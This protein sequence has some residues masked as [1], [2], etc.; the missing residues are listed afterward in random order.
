MSDPTPDADDVVIRGVEVDDETRCAHYDGDSD[1]VAIA[2]PC[3]DTVGCTSFPGSTG[4]PGE[5]PGHSYNRPY[6]TFYPCFRCHD[7]VADHDADTWPA[8][9]RSVRAVLCGACDE[10]LSIADY[11]AAADACPNCGHPFNSGCADHYDRYFNG[12]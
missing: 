7:A 12:A 10:R 8:A 9:D 3:C 1:V 6:E 2:F 4:P 5:S 11:L